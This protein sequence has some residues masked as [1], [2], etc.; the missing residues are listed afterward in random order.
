MAA[1]AYGQA[2]VPGA[3]WDSISAESRWSRDSLRRI[4]AMVDS[5]GS[6]AVVV[7]EDGRIVASWGNA[8][9]KF[10]MTS[11]RKSLLHALF[12]IEVERRTIRL[13][14]TLEQ[15]GIDDD[16]PALTSTER[17]ARVT[18]LLASRSGVY[19]YAA[20]APQSSR[21]ARPARG[22][23]RPGER[24]FYNNWDFNVLGTIYE[25]ASGKKIFS[26]FEE[27][28]ARP[29]GMEDYRA[30]D[31]EYV[32]ERG[33]RH[34][35]YTFRMSARD[36]ARVGLLYMRRGL[37]RE[38]QVLPAAW[39]DEGVRPRSDAGS[40]GSYGMLWWAARE[41]ILVPGA[42]VDAGTFAARGN[43]PHYMIVLPAR[44]LVIVH[45][46]DTETPSPDRW[47]ER[48]AVGRLVTRILAAKQ[49]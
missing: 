15:L 20:Y 27:L 21:D 37:W 46:A 5:I 48:D 42:S 2:V 22:S 32:I 7:V 28:I 23:A 31:G 45:L 41:G 49:Q 44:R 6:G 19:H 17:T 9:R 10:P 34:A 3:R 11:V 13:D 14:A 29:L 18:D 24:W 35:A 47:V 26:A 39:V 12:G 16:P 36:L 38:T 1:S 40:G 25:R 33:S 30:S 43:G 4:G 8:S